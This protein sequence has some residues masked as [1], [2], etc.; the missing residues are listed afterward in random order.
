M[1]ETT[2]NK[3]RRKNKTPLNIYVPQAWLNKPEVQQLIQ[4][5]HNV[6]TSSVMD[7]ADVLLSEKSS[8]FND[9][10]WKFLE[11]LIKRAREAK[12]GTDKRNATDVGDSTGSEGPTGQ[13]V[14]PAD[15]PATEDDVLRN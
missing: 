1:L 3:K 13:P 2:S 14:Y 10:M 11:V 12:Y 9:Q 6:I 8:Y 15:G 7:E 4:D 5:G